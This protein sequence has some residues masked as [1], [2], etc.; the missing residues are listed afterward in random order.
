MTHV[1][2]FPRKTSINSV[3]LKIKPTLIFTKKLFMI[4]YCVMNLCEI[5]LVCYKQLQIVLNNC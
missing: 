5:V 2:L 3:K 1:L 4:K